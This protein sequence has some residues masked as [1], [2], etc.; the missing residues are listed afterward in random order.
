MVIRNIAPTTQ[1][2]TTNQPP[3]FEQF[4]GTGQVVEGNNAHFECRVLGTPR[5]QVYWARQGIQVESNERRHIEYD[6]E[7]AVCSLTIK[8]M[9]LDDDGEYTCT[10]VN[11]AGEASLTINISRQ[12]DGAGLPLVPA[13]ALSS[14]QVGSQEAVTGQWKSQTQHQFV[15]LKQFQNQKEVVHQE[16]YSSSTQ[17]STMGVE[18][19]GQQRVQQS[20]VQSFNQGIDTSAFDKV[21]AQKQVSPQVVQPPS[22]DTSSFDRVLSQGQST[23]QQSMVQ[24]SSVQRSALQQSQVQSID[25]TAFDN[26]LAQ[27]QPPQVFEQSQQRVESSVVYGQPSPVIRQQQPQLSPAQQQAKTQQFQTYQQSIVENSSTYGT[28]YGQQQSPQAK[29]SVTQNQTVNQQLRSD[30]SSS[31]TLTRTMPQQQ[32]AVIQQASPKQQQFAQPQLANEQAYDTL[33]QQRVQQHQAQQAFMHDQHNNLDIGTSTYEKAMS[34]DSATI[35]SATPIDNNYAGNTSN[36]VGLKP[37]FIR[38]PGNQQNVE[39]NMVRFDCKVSGR[40]VPEVTWYLDGMQILDDATHKILVNESGI[41]SLMITIT[42]RSDAGT[43]TCVARNRFGEASV[44]MLLSVTP[45][46]PRM[47]PKFIERFQSVNVSESHG[48]QLVVRVAGVPTPKLSWQKDGQQ[49]FADSAHFKMSTI[50]DQSVLSIDSSVAD[51]SGWYQCTATNDAGSCTTRGRIYVIPH[52]KSEEKP[53]ELHLPRPTK[54]IQ[55]EEDQGPETVWLR[56]V[57]PNA[58]QQNFDDYEDSQMPPMFLTKFKSLRIMEGQVAHFDCKIQ[59]INDPT[60]VVEWF[61]NGKSLMVGS[62]FQPFHDFGFVFLNILQCVMEDGGI[63]TCRATNRLGFA[64]STVQLEVIATGDIDTQNETDEGLEK[65][66]ILEDGTR[67]NRNTEMDE[68]IKQKP[69]FLTQFQDL[70]INEGES[71]HFECR[72]EPQNDPSLRV[73][74]YLNG[75]SLLVGSRWQHFLDFGYIS[76]DILKCITEDTGVYT[77]RVVNKLGFAE[78]E[79]NLSVLGSAILL[80]NSQNPDGLQQIRY[81]EDATRFER[82]ITCDESINIKPYFL[83]PFKNVFIKEGQSAHFETRLEPANDSN[84]KVEWFHNGKSL[85]VGSRFHVF[86]DFG[87]VSLDIQQ[88]VAEDSGVYTCRA[89]NALGFSDLQVELK[90]T[91]EGLFELSSQ[92]PESLKKIQYLEAHN[93]GNRE[94]FIDES[95]S[96]RPHFLTPLQDISIVEGQVAH[97]EC[98]IE[99]ISDSTLKVEWFHN[100]TALKVGSRFQ[101]FHDFGFVSLNIL[102]SIAEDSGVYTCRITNALGYAEASAS[103]RCVANSSMLTETQHPDSLKQIQYLED[104]SKYKR[105][106]EEETDVRTAPRFLTP[107]TDV[108]IMENQTAHFECRVE[109]DND[110]HLK[111]EWF[112]NG[113]SLQVGSRFQHMLDFGFISLDILQ[114]IAEDS[115]ILTCRISNKIGYAE[116]RVNL[117]CIGKGSL[118]LDT[119]NPDGLRQIKYLEDMSRFARPQ[120]ADQVFNQPPVF[121]SRFNDS[122]IEEGASAHFENRIE[123]VNDPTMKVEWFHNDKQLTVGSRFHQFSDFGFVSLD[124]RQCVDEDG[125]FYTCRATNSVGMAEMKVNL[126]CLSRAAL[127]LESQNPEGLKQ[128]QYLEAPRGQRPAEQ[129]PAAMAPK[130]LTPFI[131]SNIGEGQ[132]AHFECRIEPTNDPNLTI[133]WFHNDKSMKT[134]SRF[135]HF[136]DFGF[137]SLNILQSISEDSG[138]YRCRIENKIGFAEQTVNLKCIDR[139]GLLLESQH[140]DSLQQIQYL[141]DEGRHQR[142]TDAEISYNTPPRFLTPMIDVELIEGQMAHFECRVEPVN[143]PNL[144]IEWFRN[145]KSLQVGSRFH[146]FHDFGYIFLNILQCIEED[147]GVY[148]CRASNKVGVAECSVKLRCVA[149][150]S[151]LLGSQHPESLQQIQYLEDGSRFAKK[152]EADTSVKVAPRFVTNLNEVSLEEGE[153]A[154]YECRIEPIN[155][156]T[157]RVEWFRN[158]KSLMIGSRYQTFHDFGYV[159]LNI[160]HCIEEDSGEYVCRISNSVGHAECK[161]TLKCISKENLLLESQNPDSL[162]SIHALEEPLQRSEPVADEGVSGPPR[163]IT[164]FTE[165]KIA[166]NQTAHFECRVEPVSD[167][168]LRIEWFHNGRALQVGSRYQTFHDFG[169]IYLNILQSIEED[170]GTYE[171]RATNKFGT[172]SQSVR[173]TVVARSN[174]VFNTNVPEGIER[175]ME[176]EDFTHMLR[177]NLIQDD[178]ES[179]KQQR[180]APIIV[181][182]PEP[183]ECAEGDVAKFCCRVIGYPRPR[184]MW[185]L[186]GNTCVNGTRYKLNYD[187]IYHL[188]VPKTRPYDSGKVEVYVRNIVGEAYCWTTLKVHSRNDDYRLVLKNSPRPWYDTDLTRFQKERKETELEKVFEEKL[189]PGGSEALRYRTEQLSEAERRKITEHISSKTL[190]SDVFYVDK[191]GNAEAKLDNESNVSYMAKSYQHKVENPGPIIERVSTGSVVEERQIVN[192]TSQQVQNQQI[193][194]QVNRQGQNQQTVNQVN[195]QGQNQQV[196]AAEQRNAGGVVQGQQVLNQASKQVQQNQHVPAADRLT[197]ESVVEGKEIVSQVSKQVQKEH[198]PG[199][200]EATRNIKHTDTLEQQHKVVNKE[201]MISGP[202]DESIRPPMFTAKVQPAII[203]AGEAAIFT[204][205]FSGVP[206]PSVTWY[207]ENFVLKDSRDIKIVTTNDSTTLTIVKAQVEDSG[208][209]SVK[210]EN[211]GGA[212]KCSANL[213]VEQRKETKNTEPPSFS[214]TIQC[215]N[216]TQGQFARL[217]ATVAGTGPMQVFWLRNNVKV[218]ADITH[219]MLE[220]GHVHTLLILEVRPEDAGTYE[221]VAINQVGE[222]RCQSTVEVSAASAAAQGPMSPVETKTMAHSGAAPQIAEALKG[223]VVPE[224]QSALFKARITNSQGGKATWFKGD[225]KVKQ[226]R[227]F[228]ISSDGDVHSLQITEAFPEDEGNYRLELTTPAGGVRTQGQLKVIGAAP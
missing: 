62:R 155:D 76:L 209:F 31:N 180:M 190:K 5:P 176:L 177:E 36:E 172:A 73:E 228:V 183:Y 204:C 63:Y 3:S 143:D 212:A 38:V 51:D 104:Q 59:P 115:G 116:S 58:P 158:G 86:H 94:S 199:N 48:F 2:Q 12:M 87:Y 167:P 144:K 22:M 191:S 164:P 157:L 136:H 54:V 82:Q 89:S 222:A 13:S 184:V 45:K 52:I 74:W 118:E 166:E 178:I 101:T 69:V 68:D 44:N 75:K 33:S 194:N 179:G 71:A 174:V 162:K 221:C 173:L 121:L 114:C 169:Y 111:V 154:H 147:S 196:P 11:D 193:V 109:P 200:L 122:I 56:H 37:S 50:G 188:E 93:K 208:I 46:D 77:C 16:L 39:G 203:Q 10:A 202:V 4:S 217:D 225:T 189:N 9:T 27:N 34:L 182:A 119:N 226:S 70:I 213:I 140:P 60:L 210:A 40:P 49:I 99:P 65:F 19:A 21:L 84:L 79:V 32:P 97:F 153:M 80:L 163:F 134:G 161:T 95:I 156:P 20:N 187:G 171:C 81:L 168:S 1:R 35:Y 23:V 91:P 145:G 132:V 8:Q 130:F 205:K 30:N 7:T 85:T 96:Q 160:L 216:V 28:N 98:R 126:K 108:H 215:L 135:Q 113:K 219:K 67:F 128:I 117:T 107:F 24:Q 41:H 206:V 149:N 29:Q 43:Y 92:H 175:I 185:V 146:A 55:P 110:P 148:V 18:Q 142:K 6:P 105:R 102:Q 181:M 207:R 124:I 103:L 90:C 141:E 139:D 125:G 127:D 186:N 64:E 120:S 150:E 214:R 170:S 53:W 138:V 192:Q 129:E 61:L 223:T 137:V 218:Q 195:R 197:A 15:D 227:Y 152:S 198:L 26:A 17:F 106:N 131:D 201:V 100:K 14:S 211:K 112:I 78:T 47:A 123:P 57:E 25:T 42:T 224:G 133:Q 88:C 72:V 151:L 159:F 83:S 66:Q 220:A 165:G